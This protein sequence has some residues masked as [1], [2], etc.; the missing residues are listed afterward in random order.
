MKKT[1]I[2]A[3]AILGCAMAV[4]AQTIAAA[5]AATVGSNVTIRG[6]VLNGAELGSIRYV[7]DPTGGISIY[8]T[9][10]SAVHRGDSIIANGTLTSY[11]NLFE[12][13]PVTFTV[14]ATNKPLPTPAVITPNGMV[15]AYEGQLVT[16]NNGIFALGGG[17][18]AGNTNYNFAAS[19]QTAQVRV[20]TT[21]TLV[22]T[23]IP[24]TSVNV[25]GI[26]S[27]FCSAPA[28]G[29]TT[30]YQLLL[31]DGND[32]VN[33]SSIYIT[34]QPTISNITTSSF[35]LTWATNI[36]GSNS[37]IKYSKD[38]TL[39]TGSTTVSAS[40]ATPHS[41][42]ISG[43]TP[44]TVYY[45][46]VYSINGTD[47]ASSSIV[48]YCTKS[49]STG[50]I[51]TYFN[52]TVDN[53]VSTGTNAIY[54]NGLV[55]DTLIAY[56]NR[57]K[58]ELEI[59]IYNWDNSSSI[60]SAVNAAAARGVKVRIVCDGSTAQSGMST[61]S[62]GCKYVYS[63][64]GAN[65]TIM[66][67]K[68]VV[69]DVNSS[70]SS[71]VWTGSTNWTSSQLSTDANN[72]IIF[73]DQSIARGYKVEFDE[74][75][76][77][78][79][80]TSNPNTTVARFGQFKKDNTPHEYVIGGKRVEQYFSPSDNTNSKILNVLG[81]ANS[82]MHTCNML[83]TRTDLAQKI[84]S[85]TTTNS[86][87]TQVLL[88]DTTGFSTQ[89][90]Y[91][92]SGVGTAN[93]AVDCHTWILHHKY[94]I[95]DQ[96][97]TASDP[98]VETGSH[99]WSTAGDTKND[100]NTVVV[101]D[102]SIANQ[103]FQEFTQR[104]TERTCGSAGIYENTNNMVSLN[105]YPNPSNGDFIVSYT[106]VNTDKVS[107]SIYDFMGKK[108]DSKIVNGTLGLNTVSISGNEYAKG[109]YLVEITTGNKKETKK[110]VVN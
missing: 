77:D 20:A 41:G 58:S 26:L 32:I 91:I 74:M 25:F 10:L 109:I 102:A 27:Q 2:T 39:A 83:I 48:A 61:I 62:A 93:A 65:Y 101:H 73:Q 98:L 75:W 107:I 104:W 96:S 44:A 92:K 40:A 4:K 94:V 13:T 64:Q 63:P 95:I 11:N 47:T 14:L 68:F 15:E 7:Q 89:F 60:T 17:S 105:I 49:N 82:D 87:A 5:R 108:V 29:C 24:N 19:S 70:T 34:A 97:N 46:K 100:E 99:N 6:I 3:I 79:S 86:L 35:D 16:I 36:N 67:N 81:T 52:R 106:L 110:L 54:L 78:T 103:Y 84:S 30:G 8:G 42:T 88:D 55:D 23:V 85:Q 53:T 66:H 51:K 18:F 50:I 69:I 80:V 12:I 72:V 31:R 37:Y 57:A 56:I 38:Q 28:S 90:N 22:G 45:A 9:A 76:G 33:N 59:A 21:T 43:L 1:I 71:Y